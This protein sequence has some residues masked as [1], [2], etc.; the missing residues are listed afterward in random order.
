VGCH[1]REILSRSTDKPAI[2]GVPLPGLL[3]SAFEY[4]VDTGQRNVLFLDVMRK[5]G[6]EYCE[7]P[8]EAAPHVLDY[9]VE[10]IADGREILSDE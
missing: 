9:D 7:H 6:V 3:A 2:S 8:A 4:L 10:L 1:K 5:R